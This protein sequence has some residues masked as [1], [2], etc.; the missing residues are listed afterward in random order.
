MNINRIKNIKDL[1][2]TNYNLRSVKDELRENL[3]L[4]LKNKEEIF[5]GIIG[6]NETIIPELQNAILSKHDFILLGLGQGR[7]PLPNMSLTV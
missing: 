1:K 6:Y 5:P 3:L 2:A 7:S 4:K